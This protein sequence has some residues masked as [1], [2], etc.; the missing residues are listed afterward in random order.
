VAETLYILTTT[1]LKVALGLFFLR[2]LTKEWQRKTFYIILGISSV[3]GCLYVFVAI[4]QCKNPK[5][6]F[7]HV[8]S[9]TCL[10]DAFLLTC[11]YLYS[12]INTIA[13]WTFVLIPIFMLHNA[14]MDRRTKISVGVI[15]ALGAV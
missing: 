10:P 12:S 2:I 6:L 7:I 4:F 9:E 15:M 13:D 1:S 14:N 3:Y 11:G 8:I 5:D